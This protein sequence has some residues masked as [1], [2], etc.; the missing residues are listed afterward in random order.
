MGLYCG[1]LIGLEVPRLDKR[2]FVFAEADGCGMG[3][4]SVATN[5][6]A[7]R[8]TMRIMDFGKMPA[9]FVDTQTDQAIRV[10]PHPQARE[11]AWQYTPDADDDWHAMFAGYQVMPD[12]ELLIAQPVQLKASMRK[13]IS[14]TGLWVQCESC[15]E[16]ITNEREV[17]Q[18]GSVLCRSCAGQSYYEV[19]PVSLERNI[20]VSVMEGS[21]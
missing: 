5:C 4:V 2:L 3:G 18:N 15:G 19:A 14:Q 20:L 16:E 8:R 1:K 10:S 7:D 21:R 17:R 9:T 12:E 11:R 6:W 13:I